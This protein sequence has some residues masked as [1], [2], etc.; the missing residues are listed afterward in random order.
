MPFLHDNPTDCL[1]NLDF[2]F[3]DAGSRQYW[4]EVLHK[5]REPSVAGD[6]AVIAA[7]LALEQQYDETASGL[8]FLTW[9]MK[10]NRLHFRH[11]IR[12]GGLIGLLRGIKRLHSKPSNPLYGTYG[13]VL[14][15]YLSVDRASFSMLYGED[16]GDIQRCI[17]DPSATFIVNGIIHGRGYHSSAIIDGVICGEIDIGDEDFEVEH[18]WKMNPSLRAYRKQ[19]EEELEKFLEETKKVLEE[20]EYF[21]QDIGS[22]SDGG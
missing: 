6:C 17:R 1:S 14:H 16:S 15:H 4:Q 7:S 13:Q 18:V 9:W 10:P 20:T 21:S 5:E 8:K 12:K 19:R 22:G 11:E 3:D 2:Q